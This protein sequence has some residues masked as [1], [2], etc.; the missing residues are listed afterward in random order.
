M[1]SSWFLFFRTLIHLQQDRC[2][3]WCEDLIYE[4]II[5]D[6]I[7]LPPSLTVHLTPNLK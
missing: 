7:N 6:K 3:K 4:F 2:S 5:T 1:V